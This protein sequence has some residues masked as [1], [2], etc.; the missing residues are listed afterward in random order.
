MKAVFFSGVPDNPQSL[1][2]LTFVNGKTC[3]YR[4]W[5]FGYRYGYPHHTRNADARRLELIEPSGAVQVVEGDALREM[6]FLSR[7]DATSVSDVDVEIHQKDGRVS[8]I[9]TRSPRILEPG[10]AELDV[11]IPRTIVITGKINDRGQEQRNECPGGLN[12]NL[13]ERPKDR[14]RMPARIVFP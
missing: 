2:G 14:S 13:S 4:D 12:L 8:S 3:W 10:P 1:L 5:S 11:A 9:S 7:F 6:R